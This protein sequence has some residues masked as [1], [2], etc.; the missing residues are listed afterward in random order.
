MS[1]QDNK[2]VKSVSAYI[3]N[4]GDDKAAQ[5]I[6][7]LWGTLRISYPSNEVER[8]LLDLAQKA[9]FSPD[10]CKA[11]FR[12]GRRSGKNKTPATSKSIVGGILIDARAATIR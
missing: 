10:S 8:V 9:G 3:A 4:I 6:S 12:S 11:E 2:A 1:I 7:S 5:T